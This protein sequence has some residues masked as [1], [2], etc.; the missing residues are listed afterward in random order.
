[1]SLIAKK[2]LFKSK[3]LRIHEGVS[4][5]SRAPVIQMVV[6][7]QTTKEPKAIN[8]STARERDRR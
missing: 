7:S 6:V 2:N 1:M 3:W 5:K 4:D 8:L